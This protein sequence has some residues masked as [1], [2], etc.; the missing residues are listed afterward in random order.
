MVAASS[1]LMMCFRSHFFG[2]NQN[3]I[4]YYY[5]LIMLQAGCEHYIYINNKIIEFYLIIKESFYMHKHRDKW[6]KNPGLLVSTECLRVAELQVHALHG[7]IH[8]RFVGAC[9]KKHISQTAKMHTESVNTF[10]TI[11]DGL[12]KCSKCFLC[13]ERETNEKCVKQD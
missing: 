10:D 11:E 3:F 12:E 13:E 7:H 2:S 4:L 6:R 8:V 1:N 9:N 5:I